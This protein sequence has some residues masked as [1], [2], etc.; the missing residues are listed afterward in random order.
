MREIEDQNVA[1]TKVIN[2]PITPL[3][4]LQ[5]SERERIEQDGKCLVYG[6]GA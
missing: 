3:T 5:S 2:T 6:L 1:T 4:A